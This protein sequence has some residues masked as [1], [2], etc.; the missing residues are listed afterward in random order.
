MFYF[1]QIF[2]KALDEPKYSSMYAQLCKRLSEEAPNFENPSEPCS[3][4]KLLLNKCGVE[5]QNRSKASAEFD[6]LGPLSP[7]D[8]ERKLLAKRKMLGNIKVRRVVCDFQFTSC[9]TNHSNV[10]YFGR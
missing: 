4:R 2:E 9:R 5:F 1:A 3:F 7:E 6:T 8:E 10:I